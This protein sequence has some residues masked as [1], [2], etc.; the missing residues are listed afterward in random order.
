ML[1][2]FISITPVLLFWVFLFVLF[3][4]LFKRDKTKEARFFVIGASLKILSYLL[5]IPK[6][7]VDIW[8]IDLSNGNIQSG[9]LVTWYGSFYIDWY[10]VF[11][12]A[13]GVAG[14]ILLLYAFWQKTINNNT[15][16]LKTGK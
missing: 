2:D 7:C 3:L 12:Q 5:L 6:S 15:V 4:I 13:V 8:G 14:L 9:K 11:V 16:S 1:E 10:N